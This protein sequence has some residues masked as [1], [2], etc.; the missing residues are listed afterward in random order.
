MQRDIDGR[1]RIIVEDM[2]GNQMFAFSEKADVKANSCYRL[3]NMVSINMLNKK[4]SECYARVIFM[5]DDTILSE[6]I[7]FFTYPKDLELI[8]TEI[9]PN[10]NFKDGKYYIEFTTD[11]FVKDLYIEASV[12]GDFSKNFFDVVPNVTQIVVFEPEDKNKNDVKFKF[13]MYNR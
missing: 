5:E 10:I 7:H 3:P 4:K 9:N 13:K 1:V 8:E 2:E 6:R 12:R 11:V